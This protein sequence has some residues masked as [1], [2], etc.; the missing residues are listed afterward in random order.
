MQAALFVGIGWFFFS[1]PNKIYQCHMGLWTQRYNWF[2][3]FG[4]R[5]PRSL[6][7]KILFSGVQQYCWVYWLI[8]WFNMPRAN[9]SKQTIS[10]NLLFDVDMDFSNTFVRR[11]VNCW[12]LP[13]KYI[14]IWYICGKYYNELLSVWTGCQ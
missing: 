12:N 4:R 8:I 7:T 5:N 9:M 3:C 1:L 14:S 13:L 10:V 11:T 2:F 6:K